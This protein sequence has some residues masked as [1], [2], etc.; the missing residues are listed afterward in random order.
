LELFALNDIKYSTSDRCCNGITTKS[1][2]DQVGGG[3]AEVRVE[4]P[5]SD[6]AVILVIGNI[7]DMMALV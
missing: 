7:N 5:V 2:K 3:F 6:L 1:V 4:G